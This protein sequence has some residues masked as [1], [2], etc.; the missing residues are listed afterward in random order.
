MATKYTGPRVALPG[1]LAEEI[2]G[3]LCSADVS[4]RLRLPRFSRDAL[5]M[6]LDCE[7]VPPA[8][9]LRLAEAMDAET[10]PALAPLAAEVRALVAGLEVAA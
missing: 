4:R 2:E 9:L 6:I 1:G 10:C 8:H 7:Q 5:V 3:A